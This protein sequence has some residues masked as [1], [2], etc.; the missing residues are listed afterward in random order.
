MSSTVYEIKESSIADRGRWVWPAS[1]LTTFCLSMVNAGFVDKS[2]TIVVIALALIY[3]GA[4]Q[5]LAG[6]WGFQKEQ[7]LWRHGVCLLWRFLDSRWA[8]LTCW[9]PCSGSPYPHRAFGCFA[10]A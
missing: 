4:T 10:C 3:G 8:S 7:R 2:A 6:M 9:P 5:I 1:A